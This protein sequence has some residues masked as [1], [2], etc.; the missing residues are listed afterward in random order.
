MIPTSTLWDFSR[1]ASVATERN[2][3]GPIYGV[4]RDGGQIQGPEPPQH[5]GVPV[6]GHV[7][8]LRL[9]ERGHAV[10]GLHGTVHQEP[11]RRV[12]TRKATL[13]PA[14]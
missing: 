6:H 13:L 8:H 4:P 1:V 11:I 14:G 5:L 12:P 9:D 7:L 10:I 2:L 3:P